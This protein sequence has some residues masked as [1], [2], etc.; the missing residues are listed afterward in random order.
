[1]IDDLPMLRAQ[2][3]SITGDCGHRW[4]GSCCDKCMFLPTKPSQTTWH[5]LRMDHRQID[6]ALQVVLEAARA[7][8]TATLGVVWATFERC[9]TTH[10]EGEEELLLPSLEKE[11]PEQVR[12]IKAEHG[13]IRDLIAKLGV[14]T[15]LHGVRLTQLEELQAILKAHSHSEEEGIYRL[16]EHAINPAPIQSFVRYLKGG[17]HLIAGWN[18]EK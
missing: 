13:Q 7:N 12:V 17:P 3:S 6:T 2:R 15:D 16:A 11:H 14:L 4:H 18:R 5:A 10:I 8:E 9:I 1:M